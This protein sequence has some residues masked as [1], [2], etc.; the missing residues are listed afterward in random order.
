MFSKACRSSMVTDLFPNATTVME[1]SIPL[2]STLFAW[3]CALH[4]AVHKTAYIGKWHL[5]VE[6]VPEYFDL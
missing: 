4:K 5:G 1:N 3:P 6:P 2:P